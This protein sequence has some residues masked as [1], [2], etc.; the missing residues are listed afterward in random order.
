MKTKI[1]LAVIFF[2]SAVFGQSIGKDH[3]K[4]PVECKTC[5][6][7]DQPT[8]RNPCLVPC[9]REEMIT[10]HMNPEDSPDVITIDQFKG[11]SD[12]YS[13]VVFSHRLHAEMSGMS[14][15]CAMCHHYNPPGNVISCVDCHEKERKRAD[16]TKPDLKGAYHRQCLECHREW[17]TDTGC[18]SCHAQKVKPGSPEPKIS[19]SERKERVHP[20]IIEPTK[21]VYKT[22]DYENGTLVTFYHNEH[23]AL[24]GLECSSCHKNETCAK[25]HSQFEK[26]AEAEPSFEKQHERCAS[27]H[28]TDN[29]ESCHTTKE[30]PP[31][32]HGKAT[33]FILKTYHADLS[34]SKCHKSSKTFTGLNKNCVNCHE[35]WSAET[36]DHK[37]TGVILDETHTEFECENCH[38]ESYSVKPTCDMC[39]EAEIS[40]PK[41]I[42]GKRI[43]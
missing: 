42:P 36:F 19:K 16:I 43:K 10:I 25:C 29:C 21:K 33:G 22:D 15:G 26:V 34:C 17:S 40:F 7:C 12:L 24:F 30:L 38:V 41:K 37:V 11:Q 2:V 35:P 1:L 31:F 28:D 13:K 23:T 8:K 14:G 5:H 32:D 39:H 6:A 4:L 18:E 3:S 27:C 9:P 20:K